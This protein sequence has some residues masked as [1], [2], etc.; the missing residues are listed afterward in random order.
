MKEQKF[1]YI[2]NESVPISVLIA[3]QSVSTKIWI[4]PMI[5]MQK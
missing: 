2:F 4:L 1:S 5:N 3:G